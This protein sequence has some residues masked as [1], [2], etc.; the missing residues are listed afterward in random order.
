MGQPEI[1]S[2]I[3]TKDASIVKISGVFSFKGRHFV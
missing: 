2:F 1:M 3:F